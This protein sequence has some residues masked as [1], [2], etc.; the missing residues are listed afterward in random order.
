MKMLAS[1]C[2][3]AA[4]LLSVSG[5][6]DARRKAADDPILELD[7]EDYGV[8]LTRERALYD[9]QAAQELKDADP[10]S[11][12]ILVST[13]DL[14]PSGDVYPIAK[15]V[16]EALKAKFPLTDFKVVGRSNLEDFVKMVNE[17]Y[18]YVFVVGT[19]FDTHKYSSERT[20]YSQRS[21]GVRCTPTPYNGGVNCTEST[22]ASTPVGTRTVE[23][24]IATDIF[25]V[26]YGSGA[27]AALVTKTQELKDGHWALS[28]AT[29]RSIGN[30][31]IDLTYGTDDESWCQNATGAQTFLAKMI[32]GNL[33]ATEPD[34]FSRTVAPSD[35]GCEE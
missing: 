35:I 5:L 29:D 14:M 12:R 9:Y 33:V 28:V 21:T 1:A 24:S 20:V 13:G 17:N 32:G 19:N 15:A 10:T 30:T 3:L 8:H 26:T 23:R 16:S 25:Y 7:E 6:S 18:D 31:A 22:S 27:A 4:S 2:L 11:T 34:K